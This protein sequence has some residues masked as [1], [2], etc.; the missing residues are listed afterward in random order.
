[1]YSTPFAPPSTLPLTRMFTCWRYKFTHIVILN[2]RSIDGIKDIPA[3]LP[4]TVRRLARS[5]ESQVL[6]W[7]LFP[8]N[9]KPILRVSA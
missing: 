3:N 2:W 7:P 1:M 5:V 8:I 9:S 4:C 6:R